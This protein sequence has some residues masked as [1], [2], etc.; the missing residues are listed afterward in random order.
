MIYNGPETTE[1]DDSKT[2]NN[3]TPPQDGRGLTT[4]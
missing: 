2:Y 4:I 3:V 1:I